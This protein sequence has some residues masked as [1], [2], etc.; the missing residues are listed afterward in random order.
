MDRSSASIDPEIRVKI[1]FK[2]GAETA[3]VQEEMLPRFPGAIARWGKCRFLFDLEERHYDWLVVYDDLPPRRN[4]RFSRGGEVLA[5]S[6]EHSLLITS[7]PGPVKRYGHGFLRQFGHV[8]TSQESWRIRHPGAIFSQPALIWFYGRRCA[9]GSWDHMRAHPPLAK[10]RELST[11]CSS[12][13]QGH[14][15]HRRR[16][17]FVQSLAIRLPGMEVFGRGVRPINDKAEALDSFRYHLAI[18]NHI[19]PHHW[20][21]KLAD[22]FLGHCLPFYIGCPNAADYFPGESFV[23][24]DL[25]DVDGS[26]A[27]ISEAIRKREHERRL[28]AIAEARRRVLEEYGLFATVSRWVE[29]LHDSSKSGKIHPPIEILSR[30]AWRLHR[31]GN[32]I[33]FLGEELAAPFRR[34]LHS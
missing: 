16:H 13:R 12:K 32:L 14:T 19:A 18:E 27:I 17:D 21:E 31:P 3:K 34:M 9:R 4:E 20:T 23:P 11:V 25:D 10:L 8:L 30:R 29:Q 6:R 26:A 1:L 2:A 22:A 28:P 33:R 5:C 15:L 24:L 7:E